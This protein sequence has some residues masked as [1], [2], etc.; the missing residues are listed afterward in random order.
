MAIAV[1]Y[2]PPAL[3]AEQYKASWN[4]GPPMAPPPGLIFHAGIGDGDEFMTMT[5]WESPER[6]QAFAPSF[7]QA[8][9]AIGIELGQPQILPVHQFFPAQS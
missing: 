9:L 5:V 3:T 2:R 4:A 6:Y 8:M 7:R 1:V